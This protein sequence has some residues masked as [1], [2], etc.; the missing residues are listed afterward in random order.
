M[1][2]IILNFVRRKGHLPKPSVRILQTLDK[3]P[4]SLHYL[5]DEKNKDQLDIMKS[6]LFLESNYP[7][8]LH[9]LPNGWSGGV[10]GLLFV[11]YDSPAA[12]Q[13]TYSNGF[14]LYADQSLIR[15]LNNF[16]QVAGP[17]INLNKFSEDNP[18]V[19][20]VVCLDPPNAQDEYIDKQ[21]KN[22]AS[23]Y[24]R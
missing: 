4:R 6:M 7:R 2:F 11:L 14:I 5:E 24:I 13:D 17:Y 19:S 1:N 10:W 16:N 15:C 23:L 3:Y 21:R 12:T 20:T 8:D 18:R 9:K 22:R